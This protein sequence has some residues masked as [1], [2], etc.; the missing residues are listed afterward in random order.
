M[1]K[2]QAVPSRR[3][4]R[5]KKR[6]GVDEQRRLIS[7]GAAELF[8]ER[9]SRAV[10]IAQICGHVGVSRP[11]FYRCFDDKDALVAQLYREAVRGPVELNMLSL[12]REGGDVRRTRESLEKLADAIFENATYAELVFVESSDPSSPAYAIVQKAFDD[13]AK[14]VEAWYAERELPAPSRTL[15]KATMVASQWIVHDAIRRKLT[16][17]A[18]QQAKQALWELASRVF[19]A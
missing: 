13:A 2:R 12:L 16:S 11:T 18:R 14:E 10:S 15:L 4:G 1:A 6:P 9:G 3:D 5:S 8:A 7:E 19:R 17:K